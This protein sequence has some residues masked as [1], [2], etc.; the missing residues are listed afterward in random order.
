MIPM[1]GTFFDPNS[2]TSKAA[3]K[4][5]EQGYSANNRDAGGA[6][7]KN[8][9]SSIPGLGGGASALMGGAGAAPPADGGWAAG[10][11][12]DNGGAFTKGLNGMPSGLGENFGKHAG[13]AMQAAAEQMPGGY[14]KPGGQNPN[15]FAPAAP[16]AD[17]TDENTTA[18]QNFM[19]ML[20]RRK[21][22]GVA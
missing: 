22:Q 1:S 15:A 10:T 2:A 12:I 17:G 19:A 13:L 16:A 21:Q 4:T 7:V 6:L 5:K 8:L 9:F 18:A 20:A 11:N 3:A 14:K